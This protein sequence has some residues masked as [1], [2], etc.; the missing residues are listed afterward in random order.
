[1]KNSSSVIGFVALLVI[2]GCT[3]K[4][5]EHME[6]QEYVDALCRAAADRIPSPENMTM[7]PNPTYSNCMVDHGYIEKLAS[8]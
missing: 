2:P 1:M 7:L 6:S 3:H 5:P 8:P 4:E